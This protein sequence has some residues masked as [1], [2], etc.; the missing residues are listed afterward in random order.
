MVE[1]RTLEQEVQGSKPTTIVSL[2]KTLKGSLS[3]GKTQESVAPS[4]NDSKIA[5]RDVKQK[6][7]TPKLTLIK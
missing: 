4:Q 6:K 5:E 2:N 7:N 3:T 1:L